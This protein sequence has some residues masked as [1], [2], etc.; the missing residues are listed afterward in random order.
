M[1]EKNIHR[2]QPAYEREGEDKKGSPTFDR[3]KNVRQTLK[4]VMTETA[5]RELEI[6]GRRT[7]QA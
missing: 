2:L 3:D 1:P 5:Q 6:R 7:S 4:S